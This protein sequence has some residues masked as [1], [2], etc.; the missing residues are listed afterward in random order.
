MTLP[1]SFPI[2]IIGERISPGYK[3][4]KALLDAND[5]AG[6]QALA[7]KQ[8]QTGASYLDVHLGTRG[9]RDLPFVT[10]LVRAL[11][12]VVDVPLCFDF[13][14]I[15]VLETAFAATILAKPGERSPF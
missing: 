9:L 2:E 8:V 12:A 13:P 14:E 10:E 5:L 1:D 6:L 4:T 7:I 3:S 11:Q 15:P